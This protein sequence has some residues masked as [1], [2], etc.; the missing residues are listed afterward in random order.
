V[1]PC[2][3]GALSVSSGKTTEF[4]LAG[5]ALM[6]AANVRSEIEEVVSSDVGTILVN[7]L[8]NVYVVAA[9]ATLVLAIKTLVVA[10]REGK[11]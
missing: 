8:E 1:L 10:A 11:Q 3:R 9:A 7:I 2:A 6:L 5:I 4:M